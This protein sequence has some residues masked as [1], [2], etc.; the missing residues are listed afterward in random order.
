[1]GVVALGFD[2]PKKPAEPQSPEKTQSPPSKGKVQPA[3]KAPKSQ[4]APR[5]A[6][7][8][9]ASA[10]TQ[11]VHGWHAKLTAPITIENG[12]DPTT[13][14]EALQY[15]SDVGGVNILVD[16]AAFRSNGIEDIENYS[17]SLPKINGVRLGTVLHFLLA[18]IDA[19]YLLHHDYLEVTTVTRARPEEWPGNRPMEDTWKRPLLPLVYAEFNRVPL[20]DALKEL[21]DVSDVSIILDGSRA[22]QVRAA[23]VTAALKNVPVDTA[24]RILAD[25]VGMEAVLMDNV[26]YVTESEHA[27]QLRDANEHRRGMNINNNGMALQNGGLGALGGG[28]LPGG[29]FGV[30]GGALGLQGGGINGLGGGGRR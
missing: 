3:P 7:G 2:Q 29:G 28:G 8:Q 18:K 19:E 15:L 23:E 10:K 17:V 30:G 5:P 6:K 13:L 21:S 14:K 16:T 27:E 26:L 4:A 25:A 24:V 11:A 12:I 1:M 9:A 20:G 22:E